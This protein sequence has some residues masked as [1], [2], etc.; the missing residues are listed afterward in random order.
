MQLLGDH[1]W[2]FFILCWFGV[3]GAFLW[4]KFYRYWIQP[5]GPLQTALLKLH[6]YELALLNEVDS[7]VIP[8][9][10]ASLR[11]RNLIRGDGE[12]VH[13]TGSFSPAKNQYSRAEFALFEQ[14]RQRVT[15]RAF[16]NS[17]QIEAAIKPL[18]HRLETLNLAFS[19]NDIR[20]HIFVSL[21]GYWLM[22]CI[23]ALRFLTNFSEGL[24]LIPIVVTIFLIGVLM[25][26]TAPLSKITTLG[27][28]EF[29]K[30]RNHSF[31]MRE[32]AQS[33][34]ET[35]STSR[36]MTIAALFPN[37]VF[38][39]TMQDINVALQMLDLAAIRKNDNEA[40]LVSLQEAFEGGDDMWEDLIDLDFD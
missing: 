8:A 35:L 33:S 32:V 36:L 17:T 12:V 13:I 38:G 3:F 40:A 7:G 19:D 27:K 2:T 31:H 16:E 10:V 9:I 4:H 29:S 25:F 14:I 18:F 6:P 39:G 5:S 24:M 30:T 1:E 28:R 15:D 22:L 23:C 20:K 37:V 34:P 11:H 26:A 21:L